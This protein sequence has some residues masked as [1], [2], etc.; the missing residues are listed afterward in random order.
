MMTIV[1]QE[2]RFDLQNMRCLPG[3]LKCKKYKL[4]CTVTTTPF[5][6]TGTCGLIV[7]VNRT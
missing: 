7:T 6:F 5:P 3:N 1:L 4:T 2:T